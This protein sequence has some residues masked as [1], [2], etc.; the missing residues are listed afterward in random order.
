LFNADGVDAVS[1]EFGRLGGIVDVWFGEHDRVN[2]RH[3]RLVVGFRAS[4]TA[5]GVERRRRD[6]DAGP[7]RRRRRRLVTVVSAT[8][9]DFVQL[10]LVSNLNITA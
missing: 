3:D 2:T 10:S 9:S 4:S 8:T 6:V 5:A 7:G 1:Y